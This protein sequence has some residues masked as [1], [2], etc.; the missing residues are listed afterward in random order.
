[1]TE[2]KPF[3]V[4]DK[5]IVASNAAEVYEIT[6]LWEEVFH[7]GPQ[8]VARLRGTRADISMR[9]AHLHPAP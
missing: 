5:V 6:R 1:V 7:G 9:V 3:A 4:G 8:W 2:H